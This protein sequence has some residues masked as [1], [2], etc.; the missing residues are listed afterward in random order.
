[1]VYL[2]GLNLDNGTYIGSEPRKWTVCIIY[3]YIFIVLNL[4]SGL[5][6]LGLILENGV[7][8]LSLK[9]DNGRVIVLRD[10]L[11]KALFMIHV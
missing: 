6:S 8:L 3:W 9:L 10:Q 7:Y 1:M 5:Y 11:V 2:L 4:D